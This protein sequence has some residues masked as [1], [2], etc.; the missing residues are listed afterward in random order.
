MDLNGHTALLEGAV[1]SWVEHEVPGEADLA[2]RA[3][4]V[5]ASAY[6]HGAT[7]SEA[8]TEAHSLV[9]SWCRHPAHQ[10][11]GIVAPLAS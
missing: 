11:L 3:A 5:A 10:H 8:C 2:M 7:V 1:R 9:R 6:E 4:I